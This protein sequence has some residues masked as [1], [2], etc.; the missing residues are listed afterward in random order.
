MIETPQQFIAIGSPADALR[1]AAASPPKATLAE[2]LRRYDDLAEHGIFDGPRYRMHYTQL[3]DGPPLYVVTGICCT[4]RSYAPLLCELGRRFRVT[5]YSL[6]GI[7]PGDG[8]NLRGYRLDDYPSDLLALADYLGDR[9]FGAIGNS[10]GS[11]VV[12]RSALADPHRID[13]AMLV[14]GFV[15]R[16]LAFLERWATRMLIHWPGRM[17]NMPLLEMLDRYNH[18]RELAYRDE[19]LLD[20]FIAESG[21]I[22]VRAVAAQIQAVDA[23]DLTA[24]APQAPLPTLIVHGEEDRLVP[25]RHAAQL[26]DLLTNVRFMVVPQCGHLPH[27]SHPELLAHAAERFFLP[28]EHACTPTDGCTETA[29]SPS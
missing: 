14:G 19:K 4:R 1:D 17:G 29:N 23:S 28:C 5:V 10:F 20:F 7:E 15:R 12:L 11:S 18:G 8:G 6:V 9:K 25:P 26:C 2:F 24:I 16:P 3:G 21:K 13:K 27:L 22:P